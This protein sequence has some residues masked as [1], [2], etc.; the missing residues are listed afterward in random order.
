MAD[1][2]ETVIWKFPVPAQ[3]VFDLDLPDAPFAPLCV[4]MQAGVAQ[5]WIQ[6]NADPN[7]A[8]RKRR[9]VVVAT[10]A[11]FDSF[12]L[13]YVGTFQPQSGLVFH[14]FYQVP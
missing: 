1:A 7:L 11:P 12:N 3:S 6:V 9:F 14:L 10:G 5:V 4:Q 8:K 2:F 13:H